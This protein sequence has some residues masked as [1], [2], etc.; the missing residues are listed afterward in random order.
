MSTTAT[1][2]ASPSSTLRSYTSPR[3]TT[4]MPSSGSTTSRIAS[5]RSAMNSSLGTA[6][7]LIRRLL[8]GL[9]QRVFESHPTQQRALDARRVLGH[10]GEGNA[11]AEHILV[12]HN[13]SAGRNHLVE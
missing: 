6:V 7:S 12:A 3:S 1:L 13:A 11:V 4:L 9:R 2:P 5:S 8:T 10:P